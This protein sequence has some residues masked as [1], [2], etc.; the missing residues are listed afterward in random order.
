M[1]EASLHTLFVQGV[2][3]K[4]QPVNCVLESREYNGHR[5]RKFGTTHPLQCRT[6]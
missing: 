4:L 3:I 1:D 2:S 5:D 6:M